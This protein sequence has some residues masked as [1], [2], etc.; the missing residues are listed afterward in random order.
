MQK[1]KF[2]KLIDANPYY[3]THFE[4]VK[5]QQVLLAEH[6]Y[7]GD[8]YPVI[9]MFPDFKK[10]FCSDFYDCED[11]IGFDGY[12]DYQPIYVEEKDDCFSLWELEEE[13]I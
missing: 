7:E 5:G 1:L 6:P 12:I 3:Y 10:A 4:N 8:L 13:T 9:I 2:Q 11:L